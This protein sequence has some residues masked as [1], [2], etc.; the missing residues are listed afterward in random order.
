M[1]IDDIAKRI[2]LD[3]Y[4]EE[5]VDCGSFKIDNNASSRKIAERVARKLLEPKE[6]CNHLNFIAVCDDCAD[7]VYKTNQ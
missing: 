3:L 5:L 4:P 2:S 6:G 1:N 7:E